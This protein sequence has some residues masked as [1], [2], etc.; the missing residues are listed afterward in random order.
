[1]ADLNAGGDVGVEKKLLDRHGIGLEGLQKGVHI[2][3]DLGQTLGK[4]HGSRRRDG[5]VPQIFIFAPVMVDDAVTD[6]TVAGVDA[7][8]THIPLPP[9]HRLFSMI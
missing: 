3:I 2:L 4:G 7:Q 9:F 6:R 1:M 5:T 8:N